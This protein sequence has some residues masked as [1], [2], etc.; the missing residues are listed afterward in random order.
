MTGNQQTAEQALAKA[1]E[2]LRT[3]DTASGAYRGLS[4]DVRVRELFL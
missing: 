2:T 3:E 1:E 4:F